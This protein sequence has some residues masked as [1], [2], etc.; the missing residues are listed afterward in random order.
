VSPAHLVL[1]AYHV[2]IRVFLVQATLAGRLRYLLEDARKALKGLEKSKL[3]T[4]QRH[5]G[6][7][8]PDSQVL[9]SAEGGSCG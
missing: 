9:T 2:A 4:H 7:I 3:V 1:V 8:N 5:T 6:N